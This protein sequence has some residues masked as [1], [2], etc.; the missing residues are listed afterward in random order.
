[1]TVIHLGKLTT[2][3]QEVDNLRWPR[4]TSTK[5]RQGLTA[6]LKRMAEI[7]SCITPSIYGQ[8]EPFADRPPTGDDYNLLWDAI[9][10]EITALVVVS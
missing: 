2:I 5:T 1:M 6:L 3:A 7:D 10:D 8:H 9:L 4:G